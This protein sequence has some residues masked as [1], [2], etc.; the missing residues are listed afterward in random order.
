MNL[1]KLQELEELKSKSTEKGSQLHN[2]FISKKKSYLEQT[3]NEFKNFFIAKEFE[4][5]KNKNVLTAR[6]GTSFITIEIPKLE[7]YYMGAYSIFNLSFNIAN[8]STAKYLILLDEEN[9]VPKISFNPVLN[10]VDEN[11]KIEA[12]I[13]KI[14][15]SII[16]IE[17]Q[18]ETISDV[19]WIFRL[20]EDIKNNREYKDFDSIAELLQSLCQ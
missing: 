8:I 16:D 7:D 12:E 18:I 17:E 2:L 15:K 11:K 3:E 6:L 5:T 1:Q 14:K 20:K 13:D 9:H 10:N 19:K 4:V